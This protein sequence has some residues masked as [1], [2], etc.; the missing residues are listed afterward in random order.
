M[1]KQ[2]RLLYQSE[3]DDQSLE[4]LQDTDVL[5]IFTRRLNTGG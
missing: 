3:D 4:P 2:R 5:L 1:S